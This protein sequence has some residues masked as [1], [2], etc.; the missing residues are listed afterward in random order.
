LCLRD[1]RLAGVE[2]D[3]K[4]IWPSNFDFKTAVRRRDGEGTTPE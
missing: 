1:A 2:Y 3:A 4:T